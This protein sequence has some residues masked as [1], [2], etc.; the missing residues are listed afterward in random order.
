MDTEAANGKQLKH[1]KPFRVKEQAGHETGRRPEKRLI[2]GKH[3]L[4]PVVLRADSENWV[5]PIESKIYRHKIWE[6]S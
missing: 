1:A 5:I 4:L 3:I 2:E 6:R